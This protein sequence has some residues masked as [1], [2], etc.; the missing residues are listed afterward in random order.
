[1]SSIVTL[2]LGAKAVCW[3]LMKEPLPHFGF[4]EYFH[5]ALTN[6]TMCVMMFQSFLHSAMLAAYCNS[7]L[8]PG[9]SSQPSPKLLKFVIIYENT[10]VFE[11][12]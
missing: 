2:I 3:F 10:G 4:L 8:A 6:Y 12:V 7:S 1:M 11:N 5:S 9:S